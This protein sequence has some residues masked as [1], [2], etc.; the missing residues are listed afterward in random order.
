MTRKIKQ[1]KPIKLGDGPDPGIG[2]KILTLARV[3]RS[4]RLRFSGDRQA[5]RD[6]I[7]IFQ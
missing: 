6:L 1:Y 7:N 2:G 3:L 5:L 4:N